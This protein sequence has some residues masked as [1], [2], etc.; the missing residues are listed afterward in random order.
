MKAFL[1]DEGLEADGVA[2]VVGEP[3]TIE[4]P[5]FVYVR[6]EYGGRGGKAVD[7]EEKCVP[8]GGGVAKVRMKVVPLGLVP[9][10]EHL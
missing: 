9:Q 3:S 4:A 2:V 6:I 1:S 7:A 10:V 8:F 5:P